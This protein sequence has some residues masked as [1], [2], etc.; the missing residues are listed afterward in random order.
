MLVHFNDSFS[1][2][3]SRTLQSLHVDDRPHFRL[4]L[5]NYNSLKY[6]SIIASLSIPA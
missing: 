2:F 6:R 3:A 1:T 5:K 4:C